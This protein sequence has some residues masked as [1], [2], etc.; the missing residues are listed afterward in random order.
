MT[1]GGSGNQETPL[2]PILNI[3]VKRPAEFSER[4][5]NLVIET[6]AEPAANWLSL[7]K[8]NFDW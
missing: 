7:V 5:V 1:F 4:S 2:N 8:S 3:Y 6:L